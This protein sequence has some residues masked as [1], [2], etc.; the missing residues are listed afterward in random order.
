M[1]LFFDDEDDPWAL[2]QEDAMV[3][4]HQFRALNPDHDP[5][6]D[7]EGDYGAETPTAAERNRGTVWV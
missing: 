5:D 2:A 1:T 7:W 3:R 6:R 4:E